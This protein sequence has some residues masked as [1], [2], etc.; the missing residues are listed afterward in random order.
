MTGKAGRSGRPSLPP[1]HA[2]QFQEI[3]EA[4]DNCQREIRN[5]MQL[6]AS[7]WGH[8]WQ[9]KRPVVVLSDLGRIKE[10]IITAFRNGG[11]TAPRAA[12]RRAVLGGIKEVKE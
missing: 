11:G 7:S 3:C 8:E 10:E 12:N 6:V 1:M 5:T 9:S 2:R 4:L